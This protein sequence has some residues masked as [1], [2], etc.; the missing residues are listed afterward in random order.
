MPLC[1]RV[2]T[3]IRV[4]ALARN[5]HISV[6][7]LFEGIHGIEVQF[8]VTLAARNRCLALVHELGV[9]DRHTSLA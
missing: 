7:Q 1:P 9:L 3:Y 6:H 5:E 8:F 4:C 2:C